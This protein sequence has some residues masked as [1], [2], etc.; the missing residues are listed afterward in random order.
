MSIHSISQR[1]RD[2]SEWERLVLQRAVEIMLSVVG[3]SAGPGEVLETSGEA[4]GM[5]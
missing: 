1:G 3:G 5:G 2:L 4:E